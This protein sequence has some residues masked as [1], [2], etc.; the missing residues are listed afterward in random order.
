MEITG[1]RELGVPIDV[2][3]RGLLDPEILKACIPGGEEVKTTGEGAYVIK[4]TTAIGPLKAKMSGKLN[5]VDAQPPTHC[6]L[7]FEGSGGA[8]GFAKGSSSVTLCEKGSGTTLK[9]SAN[10]QISGKL[11][12]LGSRMIDGVA[13]KLAA[14]FFDRFEAALNPKEPASAIE[15]QAGGTS[16]GWIKRKLAGLTSSKVDS[17]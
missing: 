8:I 10:T 6:T 3:W 2:V 11:A 5:I 13:K 17:L 4:M 1:E 12:Q 16:D 9:Y 14:E 7:I 15:E